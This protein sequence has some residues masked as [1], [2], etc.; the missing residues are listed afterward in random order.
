MS[1]VRKNISSIFGS[2]NMLL[3][4]LKKTHMLKVHPERLQ[5]TTRRRTLYNSKAS[6]S[7][8]HKAPHKSLLSTPFRPIP[9]TIPGTAEINAISRRLPVN[10]ILLSTIQRTQNKGCCCHLVSKLGTMS[11]LCFGHQKRNP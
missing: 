2:R 8:T 4:R 1:T 10:S 5:L 6:N 7:T 9:F 3:V 11:R